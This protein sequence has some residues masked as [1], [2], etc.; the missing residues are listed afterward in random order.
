[1]RAARPIATD[2]GGRRTD[3]THMSYLSRRQG[4]PPMLAFDSK[5][6]ARAWLDAMSGC[7]V[8]SIPEH[9]E[10][11]RLLVT[12]HYEASRAGLDP[13]MVLGLIQVESAFRPYAVSSAGARGLMQVMPFWID[14][15]GT[16]GD[17]LFD[18]HTNLRLG[19]SFCAT[20]LILKAAISVEHLV[21]TTAVSGAWN[22]LTSCSPP[23]ARGKCRRPIR[24]K[25]TCHV[26][27]EWGVSRNRQKFRFPWLLFE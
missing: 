18:L 20:T 15:I 1:M 4:A 3:M 19:A 17:N 21:D 27:C 24:K 9:Y 2:T 8:N 12:V 7:L 16:K 10:R 6:Q 26:R 22:I 11:E 13:Q 23:G 5:E 14:V 25:R